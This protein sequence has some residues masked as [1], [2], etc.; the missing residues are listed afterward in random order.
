MKKIF[1]NEQIEKYYKTNVQNVEMPTTFKVRFKNE[2]T[3]LQLEVKN[4]NTSMAY[5]I[6]GDQVHYLIHLF[7]SIALSK[8]I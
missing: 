2:H 6:V 8:C 7:S 1:F 3:V 4:P 5:V